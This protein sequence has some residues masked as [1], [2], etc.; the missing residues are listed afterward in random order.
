MKAP[1]PPRPHPEC[2]WVEPHRLLAGEYPGCPTDE[3]ARPKLRALLEAG[4]GL[5]VDL[6][7]E[8]E[9]LRPYEGL[10]LEEAR[11]LGKSARRVSFPVRDNGVPSPERM[12]AALDAVDRGIAEGLVVYVHCLG[13]IGRTGT[14]VGCWL[15]RHGLDGDEALARIAQGWKG[16]AKRYRAPR[17]PQTEEQH[18]YVRRWQ[19]PRDP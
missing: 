16:V 4:I 18:A 17:S 6:T 2:W 8:T 3:G 15:V 7:E 1:F 5:F 10:L 12:A 13:G 9:G 11:A 14:L 19:E